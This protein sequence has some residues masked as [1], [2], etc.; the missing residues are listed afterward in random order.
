MER[1]RVQLENESLTQFELF[2]KMR[3]DFYRAASPHWNRT[4]R[5]GAEANRARGTYIAPTLF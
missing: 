4:S 5:P 2:M 1:K 3:R